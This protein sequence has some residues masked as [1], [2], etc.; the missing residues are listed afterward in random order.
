MFIGQI[1]QI[2]L[3]LKDK[4]DSFIKFDKVIEPSFANSSLGPYYFFQYYIPSDFIN[5]QYSLEMFKEDI[6]TAF[7]DLN[8]ILNENIPDRAHG[9]LLDL[10]GR[11]SNQEYFHVFLDRFSKLYFSEYRLVVRLEVNK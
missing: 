9:E 7:I 4:M 8:I 5:E 6:Q 11:G 10:S 2:V 3:L 1:P